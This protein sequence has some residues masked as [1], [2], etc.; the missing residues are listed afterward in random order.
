MFGLVTRRRHNA[1]LAAAHAET[2]RMRA[3]RDK[4]LESASTWHG[5]ASRTSE[6]FTDTSIVND[7]LTRDLIAARGRLALRGRAAVRIL[8]AWAA[9]KRRADRLQERLDDA[10][11]LTDPQVEAGVHWQETR[12]D[13]GLRIM[14]QGAQ[15]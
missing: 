10:C 2:D 14:E 9:E 3:E 4:A 13:R 1:E 5:T 12:E 8:A 7:C 11:G 6:L 15:S